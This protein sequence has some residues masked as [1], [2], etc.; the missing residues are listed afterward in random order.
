V[1][2]K[3]ATERKQ[4]HHRSFAS[5]FCHFFIDPERFPIMDAF[6]ERM[7]RTHLGRHQIFRDPA[8]RYEAFTKNLQTLRRLSRLDAS[9][10]ALDRY[11]GIAGAIQTRR[12][13]PNA[14]L[15]SDLAAM[16]ERRAAQADRR[17]IAGE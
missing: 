7:V 8:R 6:A 13:D 5:K 17:T 10:T 9:A 3:T 1:V 12:R 2:P 4:R 16:L 15:N 11:L 14:P